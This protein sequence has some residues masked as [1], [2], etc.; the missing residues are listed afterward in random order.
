MD[1]VNKLPNRLANNQQR[2]TNNSMKT[3][4]KTIFTISSLSFVILL[5]HC[6]GSKSND[7][8]P[9]TEPQSV[10]S[11]MKTGTWKIHSVSVDGTDQSA[12]F[13]N[14]TLSFTDANFSSV[15]GSAV[16]PA[17]G[18]WKFVSDQATSFTRDDGLVVTIQNVSSTSLIISLVWTKTTLGP[19]RIESV[20]GTTV[21][22]MGL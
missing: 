6:G 21:F 7:P 2:P 13:K 3:F 12:L 14:F 15:N 11:L 22:T 18:T 10:T 20:K 17:S 4:I 16:W 8:A 1:D 5:S 19:G 9:V